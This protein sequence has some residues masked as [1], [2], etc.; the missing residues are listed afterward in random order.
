[1]RLNSRDWVLRWG[2]LSLVKRFGPGMMD[3]L[4]GVQYLIRNWLKSLDMKHDTFAATRIDQKTGEP[5]GLAQCQPARLLSQ[6]A[7]GNRLD[8]QLDLPGGT[9]LDHFRLVFEDEVGSGDSSG[10]VA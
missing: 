10:R 2:R 4:N 8:R 1:L 7:K 5:Q 6:R 9:C 3:S